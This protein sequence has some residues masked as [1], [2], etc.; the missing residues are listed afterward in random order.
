MMA[1][2]TGDEEV[3][4]ER[5]LELSTIAAIYPELK[6]K[7][8]PDQV[9]ADIDI[10]V[11]PLE[12]LP[13]HFPA[14][15]GAPPGGLPTPPDST[16]EGIQQIQQVEGNKQRIATTDDAHRLSYLPPLKLSIV[17]PKGYPVREPPQLHLESQYSWLP[18]EKL[19]EL[20]AAVNILWEELGKDQVVFSYIDHIREAAERGF[21]SAN[22]A[23]GRLEVSSDLKIALLD[24]DLKA[25]S[26]KF[27]Q[28]TFDCGICLGMRLFVAQLGSYTN[29]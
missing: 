13:I 26:A 3:E 1:D 27:E 4:D 20:E 12:P 7:S 9:A 24:F 18:E 21:D 8:C 14:A 29:R 11:E 23:R 22:N 19:R 5:A 25:R 17:L 16:N 2:D 28:Q 6:V 15:D 10:S